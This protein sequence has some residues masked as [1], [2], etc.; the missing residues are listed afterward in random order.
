MFIGLEFIL[1]VNFR[2]LCFDLVIKITKNK[3]KNGQVKQSED[4]LEET[5][6]SSCI[7][8]GCWIFVGQRGS[9]FILMK[10]MTIM[11]NHG[12]PKVCEVH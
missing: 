1:K 3:I 2:L 10:M 8:T 7:L 5:Q 11:N 4:I 9:W 12:V 6:Y